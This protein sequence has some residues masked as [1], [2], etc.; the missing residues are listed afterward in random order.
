M[1]KRARTPQLPPPPGETPPL[2]PQRQ[3]DGRF[4]PG[5]Q[6]SV[7]NKGR[8]AR[9]FHTED[10]LYDAFFAYQ[11]YQDANPYDLS[12][13]T[14][15]K[16]SP[17]KLPD[18]QRKPYS[19][20]AFAKHAGFHPQR[21]YDW[22]KRPDLKDAVE[23]IDAIIADEKLTGA[24]AGIYNAL[25]VARDLKLAERTEVG[26]LDGAPP[27]AFTIAPI[28]KGTF[29]PPDI[30][31]PE[32]TIS[33]AGDSGANHVPSPLANEKGVPPTLAGPKPQTQAEP[34]DMSKVEG[35]GQ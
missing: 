35:W 11:A 33:P 34:L 20:L 15:Y 24:I 2:P 31:A 30:Q 25:I 32:Q 26:G 9:I 18:V 1:A 7:G 17:V 16:G 21:W 8:F 27:V 13:H 14:Q 3:P 23:M 12:K 6:S 5:N 29:L 10:E 28:A 22:K 4:A 19:L